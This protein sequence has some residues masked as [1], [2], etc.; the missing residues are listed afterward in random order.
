MSV[1]DPLADIEEALRPFGY[2]REPERPKTNGHDTEASDDPWRALNNLALANLD[3]W[4][5]QLGLEQ[6]HRYA[7][8]HYG[9][10]PSF[11]PS[12]KGRQHRDRSLSI[13]PTGIRDFGTGKGY[14]SINL[15]MACGE[16]DFEAAVAWLDKRVGWSSGGP[17][18]RIDPE[19]AAEA[20]HEGPQGTAGPEQPK[21]EQAKAE[22][23]PDPDEALVKEFLEGMWIS[24]DPP[25]PMPE[26]L[27]YKLI[28]ECS[29]GLLCGK[30]STF[31]TFLLTALAIAVAAGTKFA[32]RRVVKTG[33]VLFVTMEDEDAT[34]GRQRAALE[35]AGFPQD[36]VIPFFHIKGFPAL[37]LKGGRNPRSMRQIHALMRVINK[38]MLKRF[39]VPLVLVCI[40][41]LSLI[42]NFTNENSSAEGIEAMKMLRE[43]ATTAKVSFVVID[44]H[45]K[46]D[47]AGAR[48]TSAK[49]QNADFVLAS[50]GEED[51]GRTGRKFKFTKVRSA[52]KGE[53]AGFSM[54]DGIVV[55]K[56]AEGL[57]VTTLGVEW[58]GPSTD[59][60]RPAPRERTRVQKLFLRALGQAT[61]DNP[62]PVSGT[63]FT[64]ATQQAVR[65]A[66]NS[67]YVPDTD[68][69]TKKPHD[70][71]MKAF[72]RGRDSLQEERAIEIRVTGDQE[73]DDTAILIWIP[74]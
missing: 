13:H 42:T 57:D 63:G 44:H 25:P 53:V 38:L 1:A 15:V 62:A 64:G 29:L 58:T 6:C 50:L 31:K 59:D 8:G 40:D 20:P 72:T 26:W 23:P 27:V 47:D 22:A 21:D 51:D 5:P 65:R 41:N 56:D 67:I 45:G 68:S 32:G 16:I 14:T 55:G 36:S 48:G 18:I 9:A 34:Y 37:L 17:D 4:V 35:Q 2:Q 52:A 73:P 71:R 33:G 43:G 19:P 60:D 66:F 46:S 11:R 30:F 7:D 54:K 69:G 61:K 28:G 49:G 70:A 3:L 74:L 39:S 10:V 12:P 24:G